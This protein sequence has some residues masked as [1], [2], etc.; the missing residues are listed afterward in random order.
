MNPIKMVE[1]SFEG[2]RFSSAAATAVAAVS[3]ALSSRSINIIIK[4]LS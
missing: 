3:V 2:F 4:W 1:L